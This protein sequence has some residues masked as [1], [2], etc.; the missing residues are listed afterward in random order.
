MK[1]NLKGSEGIYKEK[2]RNIPGMWD[3]KCKGTE[4]GDKSIVHAGRLSKEKLRL[5]TEIW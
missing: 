5:K 1:L 3:D 2:V 4:R